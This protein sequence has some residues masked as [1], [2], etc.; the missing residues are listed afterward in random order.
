MTIEELSQVWREESE[1]EFLEFDRVANKR[2]QRADLHAYLLLDELVPGKGDIVEAAQHD[3]IFLAV[4]PEELAAVATR[5]QVVELIRCGVRYAR[6][7][8]SLAMFT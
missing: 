8:D 2:T 7:Y 6:E 1:E 3:E 4:P 5:E